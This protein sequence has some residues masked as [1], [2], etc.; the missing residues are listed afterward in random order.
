MNEHTEPGMPEGLSSFVLSPGPGPAF[1]DDAL[2]LRFINENAAELRY[3]AV[4]NKWFEWTGV[5]WR[6]DITLLVYSQARLFC[7]N[8]ARKVNESG[9]KGVASHK[10]VNAVV[11]MA[12]CDR[13][14]ATR[15]EQW[16]SDPL[17]LNT[18]DGTVE[19]G[20]GQIRAHDPADYITR[21]TAV[22][23]GGERRR[24]QEFLDRIT[25]GN[26]TLQGF[27]KRLAGY[28][29]TG[30]TEANALFFLHGLGANGKSVFVNTLT[31]IAAD[32]HRVA[33]MEML[34]AGQSDRHP[35]ELAGLV[36]CRIATAVETEQGRRWNEA[37]IKALTGGD[38][39][40]ARFMR[41]DFFDYMPQFKLV[42]S[43]NHKP[44]LN[45]VDEA[46]RRR[47]YLV[48]FTVTIPPEERDLELGEKLKAEWPGILQ[49]AI[50][51]CVEWRR[52]GLCPPP[53]VTEATREYLDSQNIIKNWLDECTM[54]VKD[55]EELSSHMFASWKA[56]CEENGEKAGSNKAF[57]MALTDRGMRPAHTRRGRVF[58]GRKVL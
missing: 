33:P 16:D 43:G 23:P 30:L 38:R 21:C 15:L 9:A 1:S 7:R 34:I 10:T 57:S 48:P 45:T 8:E 42:V 28:C 46:I 51:G 36:G 29:L 25:D 14:V 49:W 54:E 50:E 6:E 58:N 47:L 32:Y 19:L 20:T 26:E 11:S 55:A 27:L 40:S 56:W 52:Q 31:G 22:G 4:S 5:M 13:R 41:A 17:L 35:T 37:K 44:S 18:P 39:V 3:V 2:A 53:C 24:W 12:R